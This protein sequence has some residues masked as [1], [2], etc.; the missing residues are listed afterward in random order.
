[1]SNIFRVLN[2]VADQQ[3]QNTS[4]IQDTVHFD[5]EQTEE[6][7]KKTLLLKVTPC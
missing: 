5:R 3:K 6:K 1:M 7:K 4:E 2:G